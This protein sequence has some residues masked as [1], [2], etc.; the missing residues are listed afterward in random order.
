MNERV[1]ALHIGDDPEFVARVATALERERQAF[2][3]DT[4]T[5]GQEGL[6]RLAQTRYDC[7]ISDYEMPGL[8]GI[9]F[10]RAVRETHPELP[11]ILFTGEGSE[12]VA[13][14]A[15]SAGA[16]DYLQKT[17]GSEQYELLADRIENAVAATRT[18]GRTALQEDLMDHAE[19]VGETGAWQA[20]TETGELHCTVGTRQLLGVEEGNEPATL[21][22]VV[23][24]SRPEE[25]AQ[26][27]EMVEQVQAS[28]ERVTGEWRL[29]RA[30]GEERLVE[31]SV[32]P[33]ETDDEVVALRGVMSDITGQKKRGQ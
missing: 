2:G 25:R 5:S 33:V 16:T 18:A 23:D 30:D 15:L 20:D 13:S 11:V 8:S 4:A 17:A 21:D 3:V 14:E 19:V 24:Y 10:L 12:A 29:Q 9:E 6:E 27:R 32:S 1:R 26:V 22:G 7:I 28:G 31:V